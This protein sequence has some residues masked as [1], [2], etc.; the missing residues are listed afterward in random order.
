MRKM[1][2]LWM[3]VFSIVLTLPSTFAQEQNLFYDQN[4]N[5]I[6]GD[7]FQREYNGFNQLIRIRNASGGILEEMTWHPTEERT[8]IKKTY[9]SNGS[10]HDR[11]TYLTPNTIKIKNSSGTYYENYIYQ[12]GMLV[13]QIDAD[14]NR[15]AVHDDHLGSASLLTDVNG[16]VVESTF[17]S[18]FGEIL[19]GGDGRMDYT[20]KEFDSLTQ[21]YDYN[22]RRYRPDWGK[23]LKGDPII[24]NAYDSQLLNSYSYARNN[25]YK[26]FDPDGKK[27]E[28]AFREVK[29]FRDAAHGYLIITP[30]NPQDFAKEY[31][32]TFTLGGQKRDGV[33]VIIKDEAADSNPGELYIET[34]SIQTPDGLTDTEHIQNILNAY[35]SYENEEEKP[36]YKWFP[37]TDQNEANSNVVAT[38]LVIAGGTSKDFFKNINPQGYINPGVGQ[39]NDKIANGGSSCSSCVTFKNT[40]EFNDWLSK[41]RNK[42]A[43]NLFAK[44]RSK[45]SGSRSS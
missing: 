44:I 30:D 4:G 17:Y 32:Q 37:N 29:Y 12:E 23:L 33:N 20:G 14:G 34:Y 16:N 15:Q 25:P 19:E 27:V 36:K 45:S 11:I 43:L 21:D 39:I 3:I 38:S 8:F 31:Q 26:F 13:A 24:Q 35:E 18:P 5:L 22:A 42:I 1:A 40:R 10:L 2:M 6:S 9:Y 41:Q 28:L 7:G